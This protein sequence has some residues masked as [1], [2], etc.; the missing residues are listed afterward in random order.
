MKS[1]KELVENETLIRETFDGLDAF[2]G[3]LEW[4]K[5]VF[6]S[7]VEFPCQCVCDIFLKH[8]K[9]LCDELL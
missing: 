1:G 8:S 7:N 5:M 9:S 3:S 2:E 4:L 6:G